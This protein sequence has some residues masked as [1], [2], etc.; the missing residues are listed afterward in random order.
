MLWDLVEDRF[1]LFDF[2]I[3]TVSL[4]TAARV[5]WAFNFFGG[6]QLENTF[7]INNFSDKSVGVLEVVDMVVTEVEEVRCLGLLFNDDRQDLRSIELCWCVEVD[8]AKESGQRVLGSGV[9]REL[10]LKRVDLW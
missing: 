10:S 6:C 1:L 7:E 2:C 9:G 3:L 8:L 4:H 5:F